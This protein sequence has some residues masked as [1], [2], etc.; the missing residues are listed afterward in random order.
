MHTERGHHSSLYC[1]EP[2][3]FVPLATVQGTT[4]Q[5]QTYWYQCDQVGVPQE[6]TDEQGNIVWAAD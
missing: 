3:S 6:L 4:G 5:Q 2:S 1:Y